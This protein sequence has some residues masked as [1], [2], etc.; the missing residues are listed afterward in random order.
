MPFTFRNMTVPA[1]VEASLRRYVEQGAP[2]GGFLEAV[3][4]NDLKE[5]CGR[6]DEQNLAALPAIVAYLVNECPAYCWGFKGAF[7]RWL[8]VKQRERDPQNTAR[9]VCPYCGEDAERLISKEVRDSDTG[10]QD[11]EVRCE[12]CA[13]AEKEECR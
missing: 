3:I 8:E 12:K 11:I 13:P 7:A 5:A 4:D 10:Y 9:L 6:A 1:P 2:T